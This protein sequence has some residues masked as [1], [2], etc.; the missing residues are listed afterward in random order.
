MYDIYL[1]IIMFWKFNLMTSSHVDAL[2]D[3]EVSSLVEILS[4]QY[5][6]GLQFVCIH[7]EYVMIHIMNSVNSVQLF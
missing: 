3:K 1:Q 5:M 4:Y 2:L 6:N 7:Y